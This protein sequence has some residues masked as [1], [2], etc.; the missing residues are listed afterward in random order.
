MTPES[1]QRFDHFVVGGFF[2]AQ[3]CEHLRAD[4]RSAAGSAATVYV[5]GAASSVDERMRKATQVRPSP[6]TVEFVSRRLFE[7]KTEIGEHFKSDLS[8][9]EEPQFL[10]YTVGGFF[11][12]HQD[13]N[14]PLMLLERDRVRRVSVIIPLNHQS[15]GPEPGKYCGGSLV[16]SGRMVDPDRKEI[17]ESADAGTLV[18]F[19]SETT[20]EITPVTS[21]ERLSIVSWYR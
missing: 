5:Q 17:Q 14:T 13:G 12:A 20:H 4:L 2:D 1:Y 21:G 16:F 15:A 3:A 18:A 6:E 7:C 10:R 8:D 11:V 9:C 19:R